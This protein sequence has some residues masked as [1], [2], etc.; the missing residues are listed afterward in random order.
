MT[1]QMKPVFKQIMPAD[2]W[3]VREQTD[4]DEHITTPLV[5]WGL[6][7]EGVVVGLVSG[8][9]LEVIPAHGG[10]Y[11]HQTEIDLLKGQYLTPMALKR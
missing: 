8:E 7:V 5:A 2:G 3:F 10:F 4:L 1:N 11:I 6:T 9:N